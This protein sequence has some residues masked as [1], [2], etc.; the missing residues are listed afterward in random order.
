MTGAPHREWH[1][2]GY[3]PHFDHP[4]L[5]Q[6][7]TFRLADS[8]PA[9]K[10]AQWQAELLAGA[11][12]SWPQSNEIKSGRDARAPAA[13]RERGHPGRFS[14]CGRDARAPA[15]KIE[16]H[17]R[18]EA[19]LN[20]GHGRCVLRDPR[21]AQIVEDALLHFDGER[22][23][24]LAWVIMPNHVHVLAETLAGHRLGDFIH[25]WKSFTAKDIN[26]VMGR[27]GPLWQAE[28]F[29]R[30][31][32]DADHFRDAIRYIEQ[33]PVEAGLAARAED[34]AFG[35]ARRKSSGSAGILP[36]L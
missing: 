3:L 22:Y 28:Y 1:S 18:I 10:L 15:G 12:P 17:R 36:A 8:L 34:W 24:L 30:Y 14:D 7:I 21:M 33:N 4:G 11:R 19:W 13:F 35:S 31:I 29:D 32:R 25:S 2:R 6:S 26:R 16:V 20:R 9:E 23:R 27:T 5:V